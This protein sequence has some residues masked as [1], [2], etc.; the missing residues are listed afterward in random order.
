MPK[1]EGV[2]LER[3]GALLP[4]GHAAHSDEKLGLPDA[5]DVRLPAL[6]KEERDI[7]GVSRGPQHGSRLPVSGKKGSGGNDRRKSHGKSHSPRSSGQ[8]R[9]SRLGPFV[10]V[11]TS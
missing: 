3:P 9:C 5:F 11:I 2:Y 7:P 1:L 4:C 8:E 10:V 6:P